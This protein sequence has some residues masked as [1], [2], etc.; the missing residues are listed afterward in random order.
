MNISLPDAM[1]DFVDEQVAE[2]GYGT[3]SEYVRDLI[4]REQ[5]RLALR[6]LLLEGASSPVVAT[7]D[8]AFFDELRAYAR[9][10]ERGAAARVA[11]EPEPGSRIAGRAAS[12]PASARGAGSRT[13]AATGVRGR[14]ATKARSGR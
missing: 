14:V 7:A 12:T 4:R 9:S 11:R 13:T 2:R 6:A 8:K 10:P 1:R 3:S 5:D